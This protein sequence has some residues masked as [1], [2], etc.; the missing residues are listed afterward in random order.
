MT[1]E[2]KDR[3]EEIRDSLFSTP[4]ERLQQCTLEDLDYIEALNDQEF[5]QVSMIKDKLIKCTSITP[6]IQAIDILLDDIA[7]YG[8]NINSARDTR[9]KDIEDKA[10]QFENDCYNESADR[11]TPCDYPD[12]DGHY[13]CPFDAQ[14]GD[15]CRNYCGLGVDE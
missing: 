12:N 6:V 14:G 13:N 10:H 15:D 1:D 4:D 8:D 7:L 5:A 2:I 11:R 9:L 3:L